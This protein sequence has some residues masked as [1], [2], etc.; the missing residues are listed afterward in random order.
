MSPP[1]TAWGSPLRTHLSSTL[2]CLLCGPSSLQQLVNFSD[3]QTKKLLACKG[4]CL[5][6]PLNEGGT[7]SI[8]CTKSLLP[9][10]C[11]C[12]VQACSTSRHKALLGQAHVSAPLPELF[13]SF[14]PSICFRWS[15]SF[16]P[17]A[18][19]PFSG[20]KGRI[21]QK[22]EWKNSSAKLSFC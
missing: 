13:A 17:L 11:T 4:C 21:M 18:Y 6:T 15:S 9:Q 8:I 22:A 1:L 5:V 7:R 2:T 20:M 10:A 14:T 3:G 19:S 16:Q 12:P